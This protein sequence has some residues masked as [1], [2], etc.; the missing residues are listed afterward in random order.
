MYTS[1]DVV[2]RITPVDMFQSTNVMACKLLVGFMVCVFTSLASFLYFKKKHQ[3]LLENWTTKISADLHDDVGSVLCALAMQA[4][5]LETK[6]AAPNKETA[7]RIAD[8]SRRAMAQMRETVWVINAR[9]N[10]WASLVDRLN[11]FANQTLSVKEIDFHLLAEGIDLEKPMDQDIRQHLFLIGKEAI[12]NIVRH[13]NASEVIMKF[14]QSQTGLEMIIQ[15]NGDGS[16]KNISE[17]SG[18]GI[19]NMKMRAQKLGG[20]LSIVNEEGFEICLRA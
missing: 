19:S 10:N 16:G 15:D 12:T 9:K 14:H 8:M 11:E 13:S 18:L 6:V 4:E 7:G 5:L 17:V 2:N 3:Q 1:T 20:Q